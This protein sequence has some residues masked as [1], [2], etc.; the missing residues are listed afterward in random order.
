MSE[1]ILYESLIDQPHPELARAMRSVLKPILDEW[2]TAIRQVVPPL[3]D[4]TFEEA[5]DHVPTILPQIASVVDATDPAETRRLM[6]FSP[7]QGLARYHQRYDI[8]QLM[9]EDRMLRR[10]IVTQTAAALGRAMTTDEMAAMHWAIDVMLHDAVVAFADEQQTQ[11]RD[12][13]EA[14]TRYTAFLTHDLRNNL[15]AVTLRLQL[16]R[17]ELTELPGMEKHVTALDDAQQSILSTIGGMTR[18]LNSERDR[19]Q[20]QPVK[21]ETIYLYV[22][23]DTLRKQKA[24]EAEAKG[25]QLTI[26]V[27]PGLTAET[28]PDVLNVILQN[29]VGNAI[30]YSTTGTVRIAADRDH[31]RCTLRVIDQGPGIAPDRLT[32]IFDAF[33]RGETHGQDGLGLGLTIATRAARRLGATLSVTSKLGAGSTFSFAFPC[34]K[35]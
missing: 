9:Q 32:K 16:M 6:A 13:A 34:G 31:G 7:A 10:I 26:E 18:L 17:L 23:A 30:K 33:A 20:P 21:K 14:E 22:L 35:S 24:V 11:I 25:L 3:S 28:D 1:P 29:L 12:A 27:E 5:S 4:S 2:V 19:L 8:H 15:N